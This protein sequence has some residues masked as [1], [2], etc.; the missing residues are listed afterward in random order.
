VAILHNLRSIQTGR[1]AYIFEK[2]LVIVM[3]TDVASNNSGFS[4][5][6]VGKLQRFGDLPFQLRVIAR[7]AAAV[8]GIPLSLDVK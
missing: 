1:V 8:R 4:V 2:G 3:A 5:P 7:A 6:N